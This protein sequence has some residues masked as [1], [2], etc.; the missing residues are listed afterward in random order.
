MSEISNV[1]DKLK[2]F[3]KEKPAVAGAIGI[4]VIGGAY[5]LS[6]SG[7]GGLSLNSGSSTPDATAAQAAAG[8]AG[9]AGQGGAS[10]SGDG[11]D[12]AGLA[13]QLAESQSQ[14]AG[15]IGKLQDA[16]GAVVKQFND[17]LGQQQQANQTGLSQLAAQTN[18]ALSGFS[19]QQQAV[20]DFAGFASQLQN[21]LQQ[22]LNAFRVAPTGQL[23]QF[24]A[25]SIVQPTVTQFRL[26]ANF[27]VAQGA[28][29]FGQLAGS[30]L[31]ALPAPIAPAYRP[32]PAP[33]F[34]LN[35]FANQIGRFSGSFLTHL[36]PAPNLNYLNSIN[37]LSHQV[38]QQQ[39]G[40]I[41]NAGSKIGY[42]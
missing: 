31:R 27:S 38:Y 41:G 3:I 12:L 5:L 15:A 2:T 25:P 20:P 26:P 22:Q 33:S 17:A 30:F 36:P 18:Q 9:Q 35:A 29:Q 13:N 1:A 16:L 10:G 24:T 40:Q 7:A 19:A 8:Q 6:R 32:S 37:A 39:T 28:N 14:N 11:S 21:N 23:Q 4:G 42:Q 34:N